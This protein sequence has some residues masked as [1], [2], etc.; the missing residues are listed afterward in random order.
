MRELF[1]V[2]R[3]NG[4]YSHDLALIKLRRSTDGLGV[5]FSRSVSPI[6]LPSA[7]TLLQPGLKCVV[8]GW[9]RIYRKIW[10]F[11]GIT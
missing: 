10:S 5:R 9:G 3:R 6:C 4:P 1:V 2:P 11:T 7:R 8:S